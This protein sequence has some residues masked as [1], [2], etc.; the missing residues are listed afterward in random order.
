MGALSG[1]IIT[2]TP[3]TCGHTKPTGQT[4][5]RPSGAGGP[6]LA[7]IGLGNMGRGMVKNLAEKGQ[8]TSPM[9]I[10][11]RTTSRA[12]KLASSLPAGKAQVVTSIPEAVE[13]ADIIFTCVGDDAV[14]EETI[15]T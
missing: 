12:E 8:F 9:S 15:S 3:P 1:R 7:W 13:Q 5:S 11:N 2:K 14:I 4:S 10:Y 6:R